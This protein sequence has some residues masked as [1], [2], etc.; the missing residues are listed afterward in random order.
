MLQGT[1]TALAARFGGVCAAVLGVA[2]TRAK[3]QLLAPCG[4]CM[5]GVSEGRGGG[6]DLGGK[7]RTAATAK[8]AASRCSRYTEHGTE[9]AHGPPRRTVGCA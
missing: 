1:S 9:A 7:G 3:Y 5:E 6:V 4:S 2:A 8:G